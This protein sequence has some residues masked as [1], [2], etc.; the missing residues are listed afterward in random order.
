MEKYFTQLNEL[1]LEKSTMNNFTLSVRQCYIVIKDG[2]QFQTIQ[3][4]ISLADINSI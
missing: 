1:L 2:I 3:T 4:I